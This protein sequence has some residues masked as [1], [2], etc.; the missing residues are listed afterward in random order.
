MS[1]TKKR[2]VF[3]VEEKVYILAATDAGEMCYTGCE[4][5][6]ATSPLNTVVKNTKDI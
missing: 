4:L 1:E 2:K 3:A 5:G 6:V